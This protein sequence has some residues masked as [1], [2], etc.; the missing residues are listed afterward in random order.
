VA[1]WLHDLYPGQGEAG[2]EREW[3]GALRPDRVA[4]HLV[5]SELAQRPDLI[6][7]LFT[8]LSERRAG[9]ALATLTRGTLTRLEAAGLLRRALSADFEH[10]AVPALAAAIETSPMLGDL[11]GDMLKLS[12]WR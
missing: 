12:R 8:G 7:A 9:W 4:E 3:I 10:L 2:G 1:R 11:L 6:P 5:V